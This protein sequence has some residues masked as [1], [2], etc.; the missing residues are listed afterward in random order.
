MKNV[1]AGAVLLA[2]LAA[3][4]PGT[5][6]AGHVADPSGSSSVILV[7]GADDV[8]AYSEITTGFTVADRPDA[9]VLRAR[10]DLDEQSLRIRMKFDDLRR[11]ATQWY[12]VT[13]R[14]PQE[15]YWYVLEAKKDHWRGQ[16]FAD[17]D[18]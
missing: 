4:T 8:W 15:S 5:T 16:I 13:V 1:L 14:T 17:V 6:A 9:D 2:G 10:I 7:D 12:R 3:V 18:G 11:V